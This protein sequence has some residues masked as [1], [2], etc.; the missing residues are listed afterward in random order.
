[1]QGSEE[2]LIPHQSE[3]KFLSD[4]DPPF[5][6]VEHN[7]HAISREVGEGLVMMSVG[8]SDQVIEDGSVSEIHE[9]R[10]FVLRWKLSY[11]VTV[12]VVHLPAENQKIPCWTRTETVCLTQRQRPKPVFVAKMLKQDSSLTELSCPFCRFFGT[13]AFDT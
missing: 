5:A 8:V 7:H 9:T 4:V 10:P 1:M 13:D 2:K 6:V 12:C 11:F 3:R